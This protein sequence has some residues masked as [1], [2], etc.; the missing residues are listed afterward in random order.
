[1]ASIVQVK[2]HALQNRVI[3]FPQVSLQQFALDVFAIRAVR[4]IQVF[5]NADKSTGC[6]K[7]PR[8]SKPGAPPPYSD[9]TRSVRTKASTPSAPFAERSAATRSPLRNSNWSDRYSAPRNAGD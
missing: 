4:S 1:A 8:R 7:K 6:H 5:V 2:R 9:C 3:V